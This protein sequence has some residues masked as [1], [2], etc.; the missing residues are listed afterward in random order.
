MGE[1]FVHLHTRAGALPLSSL[2]LEGRRRPVEARAR[3]NGQARGAGAEPEVD[4]PIAPSSSSPPTASVH[5][6]VASKETEIYAPMWS[7]NRREP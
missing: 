4:R 7:T 2:P 6:F 1:A 5:R 3:A